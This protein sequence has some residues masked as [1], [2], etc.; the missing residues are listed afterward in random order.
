MDLSDKKIKTA[1]IFTTHDTASSERFVNIIRKNKYNT[2]ILFIGDEVHATGAAKQRN[3]LLPEYDYRIGLSATPE[4]MFD[5]VALLSYVSI[6][7][8]NHLSSLLQMH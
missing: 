5:E 3:A 2:K 1:I 4:R 8:I 7:A 6:L